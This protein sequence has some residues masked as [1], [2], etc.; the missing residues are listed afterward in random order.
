MIE[1]F[2]PYSIRKDFPFFTNN[3]DV[4]YFDN[5]ATTQKPLNTILK[6]KEFYEKYNCN[7]FRSSSN[8]SLKTEEMCEETRFKIAEFINCEPREIFF[9]YSATY[10]I[11]LLSYFITLNYLKPD[12]E[13][14]LTEM[15]HHAA[16]LPFMN[17]SK[18]FDF[19]LK[20]WKMN[21]NLELDLRDLSSLV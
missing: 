16:L 3:P 18:V 7:V 8:F 10:G 17:I 12:D 6:E 2:D 19:K 1:N 15:E 5:A 11:N 4:I 21:D 13:V 20:L 9:T 14:I